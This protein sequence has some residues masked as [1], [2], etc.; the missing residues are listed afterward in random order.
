[1]P[2][3]DS[4]SEVAGFFAGRWWAMVLRGIV[5][6]AFGALAFCWPGVTLGTLVLLFGFY[7]IADGF[8]TLLAAIGGRQRDR[9]DRWLLTLEG[10]VGVWA[11]VVTLRVPQVTAIALVFFIS[12]W[13][14]ATG[15]LRI[16]TA[17]RLRNEITGEVWLVLSGLVAVLFALM[18]MV[19][20]IW[21][22]LTLIW[23]IA[24]YALIIG[25]FLIMLGF[26][27]R[28]PHAAA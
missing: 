15:F 14:M 12:I 8:F 28:R 27:L 19:R 17:V 1:M 16:A 18:L 24:G 22:A 25:I 20:P 3:N 6:I 13:A 5:A 26:E 2:A 21:G 4:F 9:Y 7:A 11:G 10:I 23:V